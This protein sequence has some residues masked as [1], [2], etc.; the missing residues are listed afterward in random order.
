MSHEALTDRP[1]PTLDQWLGDAPRGEGF[2]DWVRHMLWAER[3]VEDDDKKEAAVR[4]SKTVAIAVVEA[5]RIECE[6][7]GR[8]DIETLLITARSFGATLAVCL[9]SRLDADK[10]P[11]LRK[12]GGMLTEEFSHA[13]RMA[14]DTT[15]RLA[16]AKEAMT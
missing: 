1:I 12:I 2:E 13:V 3:A 7:Y 5:L 8:D 15:L 9:F 6:T 4:I 11:P 10:K 14:T 16:K